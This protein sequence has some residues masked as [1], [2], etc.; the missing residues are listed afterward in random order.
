LRSDVRA[1]SRD[2]AAAA[3]EFDRL[4]GQ[5]AQRF[6][7]RDTR[8]EAGGVTFTMTHP[9]TA[10]DLIDEEAF[11][12]DERLPYWADIWPSARVLADHVARHAGNDRSAL[13]LGCGTGLVACALAHAGYRVTVSDYYAEALDVARLN[14][15]R[16]GGVDAE[17]L[18]LDWRDLPESLP[19]FD[20]VAAA[21][22]LYER[23]YG[24]LVARAI[25]RLLAPGAYAIIADP[26]RVAL[27]LFLDEARRLGLRI[28]EEWDVDH[29]Q[30]GQRHMIR[31]RVL[32]RLG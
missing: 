19:T 23:P 3:R 27:D 24:P 22:V 1:N 18:L 8:V 32:Q 26:G 6:A 7:M 17:P 28:A 11:S 31:L 2:P 12:R 20:V 30:E 10:E 21:D 9:R 13:D 29:A 15:W 25:H 4:A 5:L 14:V 16:H